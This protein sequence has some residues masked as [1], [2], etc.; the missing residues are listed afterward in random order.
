MSQTIPVRDRQIKLRTHKSCFLGSDAV[1]WLLKRQEATDVKD[2]VDTGASLIKYGLI[3]NVSDFQ[4][5]FRNSNACY[6]FNME[7]IMGDDDSSESSDDSYHRLMEEFV[8]ETLVKPQNDR[9]QRLR[10]RPRSRIKLWKTSAAMKKALERMEQQSLHRIDLAQGS[11]RY[12]NTMS[13]SSV[14]DYPKE[15][16]SM[17]ASP[18]SVPPSPFFGA[19]GSHPQT[20]YSGAQL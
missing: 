3:I 9:P 13:I 4:Q 15:Q 16:G 20:P 6:R 10:I 17:P 18:F 14:S 11:L 2:A 5:T 1:S 7:R 8:I 19:A 12:D